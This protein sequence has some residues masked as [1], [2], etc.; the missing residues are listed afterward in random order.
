MYR[1]LCVELESIQK[2]EEQLQKI[3]QEREKEAQ[4]IQYG[5]NKEVLKSICSKMNNFQK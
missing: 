3:T 2:A 1:V 5:Q 4:N